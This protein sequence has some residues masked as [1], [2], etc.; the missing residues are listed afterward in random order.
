[1]RNLLLSTSFILLLFNAKAQKT[2]K[3]NTV[4]AEIVGNG[5]ILSANYERQLTKKP[6]LGLHVGIGL[7]GDMPAI[8]LGLKYIILFKNKKSL[9]EAGLGVTLMES[10]MWESKIIRTEKDPYQPGYIP[11]IGYRHHTKYGLMWRINF[12]PV[13]NKKIEPLYNGGLSIGWR[14]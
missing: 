2:F 9:F 8:P 5:L 10:E 3:Q 6:G 14:F 11:S 13:Y 7:G 12:T 4:Y 1:M